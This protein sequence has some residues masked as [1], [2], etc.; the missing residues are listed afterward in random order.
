MVSSSSLPCSKVLYLPLHPPNPGSAASISRSLYVPSIS[1]LDILHNT[2]GKAEALLLWGLSCTLCSISSWQ[3]LSAVAIS[4][5]LL[6]GARN[7]SP[8]QFSAAIVPSPPPAS[9]ALQIL[10]ILRMCCPALNFG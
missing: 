3:C 6:A 2:R 9:A 7:T 4:P 1:Q 10:D 8:C 5:V